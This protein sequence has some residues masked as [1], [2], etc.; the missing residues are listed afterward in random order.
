[1]FI[2]A[3]DECA[4]SPPNSQYMTYVYTQKAPLPKLH[5]AIGWAA[6]SPPPPGSATAIYIVINP[7]HV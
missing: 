2:T 4:N 5:G 3:C 7:T 1:M 6:A